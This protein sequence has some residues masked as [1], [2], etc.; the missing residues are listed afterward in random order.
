[1][2]VRDTGSV[3]TFIVVP[4]GCPTPVREALAIELAST[5]RGEMCLDV[6]AL[7]EDARKR[8]VMLVYCDSEQRWDELRSLSADE[9]VTVAMIL[10]LEVDRYARALA[11]GASGVVHYDNPS[12][13]VTSVLVAAARGEVVLPVYA[14]RSLGSAWHTEP[15]ADDLTDYEQQ[16]LGMLAAGDRISDI[17]SDLAYSERTIR[18]QLQSVYLKLGVANRYDAIRFASPRREH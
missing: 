9:H 5:G 14:A 2:R 6:D 3:E 1:M 15:V 10:E 13:L 17:A 12:S 8:A 11:C 7:D 4:H 16:L 18:R